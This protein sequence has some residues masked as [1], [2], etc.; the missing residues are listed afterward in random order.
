MEIFQIISICHPFVIL[1]KLHNRLKLLINSVVLFCKL[2]DVFD[3][4][5]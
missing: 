3:C 1:M 2:H 5:S 4:V